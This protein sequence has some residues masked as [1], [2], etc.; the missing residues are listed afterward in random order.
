M[1]GFIIIKSFA[2]DSMMIVS[3][4][5]SNADMSCSV[6]AVNRLINSLATYYDR[7]VKCRE[8]KQDST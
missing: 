3:R 8:T 6:A 5:S 1:C 7:A 4:I 2:L